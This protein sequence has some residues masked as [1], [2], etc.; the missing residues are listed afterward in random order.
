MKPS[1]F[2]SLLFLLSFNLFCQ[3][4]GT[5]T[6]PRDGHVYKTVKIGNQWILAENFA[7]K[8][9]EG[10][11]WPLKNDSNNVVRYGYLYNYE[12]ALNIAPDGWHLPN[13]E[14][15]IKFIEFLVNNHTVKCKIYYNI[16]GKI[17][18]EGISGFNAC[19][20]G[21]R[22]KFGVYGGTVNKKGFWTTG[23]WSSTAE[24]NNAWYIIINSTD[25]FERGV[26]LFAD[27]PKNG[28]CVRLFKNVEN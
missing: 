20:S 5:M 14:E 16:V 28:F 27:S 21:W 10:K 6:D 25:G 15:W 7:Y 1:V 17:S 22:N 3:E 11:Y 2:F 13:Q 24:D 19:G 23:Y 8:P 12:T 9:N 4:T 18:F 26:G